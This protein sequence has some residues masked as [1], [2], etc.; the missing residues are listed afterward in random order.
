MEVWCATTK[1]A[2]TLIPAHTFFMVVMC[3]HVQFQN[4]A[5]M[6]VSPFCFEKYKIVCLVLLKK[7]CVQ[8]KL[9]KKIV[10]FFLIF[11]WPSSELMMSLRDVFFSS[12]FKK[13]W[14]SKWK[15]VLLIFPLKDVSNVCDQRFLVV[16]EKH[17]KYSDQLKHKKI[18]YS[19]VLLTLLF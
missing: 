11:W 14:A 13:N 7:M 4:A 16:N 15:L 5:H 1:L 10:C 2:A 17:K 3:V 9:R 19:V 18:Y 6:I 12:L 8:L